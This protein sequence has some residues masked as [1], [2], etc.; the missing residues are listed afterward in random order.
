MGCIS[1]HPLPCSFRRVRC[2]GSGRARVA[3]HAAVLSGARAHLRGRS[4]PP[5]FPHPSTPAARHQPP[6]VLDHRRVALISSIRKYFGTH[7]WTPR[8]SLS[9][10]ARR[11]RPNR[12]ACSIAGR[13]EMLPPRRPRRR[14]RSGRGRRRRRAAL[15]RNS[16]RRQRRRRRRKR[17]KRPQSS[18]AS[19]E[20]RA[21][22]AASHGGWSIAGRR[23]RRRRRRRRSVGRNTNRRVQTQRRSHREARARRGLG[24]WRRIVR[25]WG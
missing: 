9:P 24:R 16:P 14:R 20:P 23:R 13:L 15:K 1:S 17:R 12:E 6:S 10:P 25:P 21:T 11:G 22:S 7:L 19:R 3:S 8:R 4:P 2:R 18:P 5:I